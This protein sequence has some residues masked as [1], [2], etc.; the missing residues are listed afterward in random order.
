MNT[1]ATFYRYNFDKGGVKV[2]NSI[3]VYGL[4]SEQIEEVVWA[5]KQ[6]QLGEVWDTDVATDI[7]ATNYFSAFIN[8]AA[9]CADE[10][11]M[12]F[13]YYNEIQTPLTQLERKRILKSHGER[14]L[15][16]LI[17]LKLHSFPLIISFNLSEFEQRSIP[18]CF[19]IRDV[20]YHNKENICLDLIRKFKDVLG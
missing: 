9:L 7:I 14:L 18:N 2:K 15:F 1:S 13:E 3:L 4:S 5:A 20:W 17:N 11:E 6:N 19:L 10:K 12:I 16:D 8:F